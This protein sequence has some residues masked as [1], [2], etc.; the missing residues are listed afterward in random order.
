M[1]TEN[2]HQ[3]VECSAYPKN[4]NLVQ[5]FE[6]QVNENK[7]KISYI[8]Q[9]IPITYDELNIR[10]NQLAHFIDKFEINTRS[11]IA[12]YFERNTETIVAFLSVL[13]SG[14]TYIPIDIDAPL[15]LIKKIIFF[16]Y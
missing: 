14:N 11:C 9:D 3:Q 1:Y 8:Y 4:K 12:I 7:E 15:E 5:L 13:K 10:A 2:L 16:Y 6:E